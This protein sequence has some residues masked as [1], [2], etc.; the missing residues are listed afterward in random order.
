MNEYIK[1][2]EE[3]FLKI[4]SYEFSLEVI[5][6]KE[7]LTEEFI[8]RNKEKIDW[9]LISKF[10]DYS[11]KFVMDHLDKVNLQVIVNSWQINRM[12]IEEQNSLKQ[13]YKLQSSFGES[14]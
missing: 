9:D 12:S 5:T 1:K 6:M 2:I 3:K 8:Q 4:A 10:Y 7:E 14:L 13:I 11:Y